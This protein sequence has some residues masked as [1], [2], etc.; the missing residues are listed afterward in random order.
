M[1]QHSSDPHLH[2]RVRRRPRSA[3]AS[4]TCTAPATVPR[5]SVGNA[6]QRRATDAEDAR[7]LDV[8]QAEIL[9]KPAAQ[10]SEHTSA[11]AAKVLHRDLAARYG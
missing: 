11:L 4:S 3:S 6:T 8:A 5:S 7:K 9:G 10:L 2:R 1:L